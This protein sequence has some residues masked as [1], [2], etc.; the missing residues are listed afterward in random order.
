MDEVFESVDGC[1]FAFTAFIRASDNQ[2][3]IVFSDGNAADL[4]GDMLAFALRNKILCVVL[5]P[6]SEI[7]WEHWV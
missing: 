5:S 4:K 3:F 1:D 7:R 6:A 2:D